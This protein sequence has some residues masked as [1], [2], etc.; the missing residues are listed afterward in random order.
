M[1]SLIKIPFL[2]SILVCMHITM[3]PPNNEP[4]GSERLKPSGWEHFARLIPRVA[5]SIIWSISLCE[6]YTILTGSNLVR[7]IGM[8]TSNASSI[9]LTPIFLLGWSFTLLGT[10]MRIR[11]YEILGER[12][13]FELAIRQKHALVTSGPYAFVRHPSYTGAI[14]AGTGA[15]L[16]HLSHGSWVMEGLDLHGLGIQRWWICVGGACLATS[17]LVPRMNKEDKMLKEHFG[18]VWEKWRKDVPY[19]LVPGVY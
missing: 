11:C 7:I 19:R 12:F 2:A 10:L 5:K 4:S 6:I 9:S 3:T 13:T 16:A 17:A 1:G 18:N 14:L 8:P 15:A